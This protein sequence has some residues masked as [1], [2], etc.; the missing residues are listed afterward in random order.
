MDELRQLARREGIKGA[1]EMRKEE[2][3]DAISALHRKGKET[4][5]QTARTPEVDESELRTMHMDQLRELAKREGIKRPDAMR[6]DELVAA[7]A[8]HH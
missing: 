2:L 6:K 8:G 7:I 5:R 1:A 4:G 3:V